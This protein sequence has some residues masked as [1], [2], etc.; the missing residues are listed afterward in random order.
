[1]W[2][3]RHAAAGVPFDVPADCGAQNLQVLGSAPELPQQ[4]EVTIS[5]LALVREQ[6]NG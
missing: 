6:A 5:N 3:T 4:V 2:P 1:M